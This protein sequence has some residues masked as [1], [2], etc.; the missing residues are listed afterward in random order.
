MAT[1]APLPVY[2]QMH[3]ITASQLI[4][5]LHCCIQTLFPIGQ[6]EGEEKISVF[7]QHHSSGKS[8]LILGNALSFSTL[9]NSCDP[10]RE[11]SPVL[12][13]CT[14]R[15]CSRELLDAIKTYGRQIPDSPELV[16]I[17]LDIVNAPTNLVNPHHELSRLIRGETPQ[18]LVN[19]LRMQLVQ[20]SWVPPDNNHTWNGLAFERT[21]RLFRSWLHEANPNALQGAKDDAQRDIDKIMADRDRKLGEKDKHVAAGRYKGELQKRMEREIGEIDL[22]LQEKQSHLAY[23]TAETVNSASLPTLQ[24]NMALVIDTPE[25]IQLL[26]RYIC[27]AIANTIDQALGEVSWD[28]LGISFIAI[29]TLIHQKFKV[30]NEKVDVLIHSGKRTITNWKHFKDNALAEKIDEKKLTYK[31]LCIQQ[32]GHPVPT[33]EERPEIEQH[34]KAILS[35]RFKWVTA[36]LKMADEQLKMV[37][38]FSF[39][40]ID[41][42]IFDSHKKE[43][44]Q[45]LKRTNGHT[46]GLAL[47]LNK[48]Y[49]QRNLVRVAGKA[50]TPILLVK[51]VSEVGLLLFGVSSPPEN[52]ED[53]PDP[54]ERLNEAHIPIQTI[55]M[56]TF[57]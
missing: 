44:L 27:Q 2:S 39:T 57:G 43:M 36:R 14:Y 54:N 26:D 7:F 5:E 3:H 16:A 45:I 52:P 33:E 50:G 8:L 30:L 4:D 15:N 21:D 9:R 56:P 49:D 10:L 46:Y 19:F 35:E 17:E 38:H 40:Q 55:R 22:I 42:S 11:V 47:E 23:L 25:K 51:R 20:D 48:R 12:F 34:W 18:V 6:Y 1:I 24:C 53:R 41:I 37:E 31:D 29:D 32:L 28:V 13:D